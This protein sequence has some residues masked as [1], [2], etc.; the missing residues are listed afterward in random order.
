[1]QTVFFIGKPGC[2]KGTQ[3]R[4]L[5]EKTGWPA[6]SAGEQ[7]RSI[8]REDTPVGHKVKG[9]I[10]QGLLAPHWFAMYLYQKSLFALPREA[11][12][13]FDG[14]NRKP[15]EAELIIESL[16]WLDRPFIVFNIVISD[17]EA[18]KRIEGRRTT[19]H[20][21]DDQSVETRLREYETYTA[22]ALLVF[23]KESKLVDVDGERPPE[24]I[25]ADIARALELP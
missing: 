12:A 20:R 10:D 21:A 7:F 25:A 4:L 16:G 2:G 13:I 22:L 3:A 8:A 14:F 18:E 24:V 1:M 23:Q 19:E 9:E 17:K 11:S 5:A 6:I 15:Q